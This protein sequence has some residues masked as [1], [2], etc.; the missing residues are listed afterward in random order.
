MAYR[1]QGFLLRDSGDGSV[2]PIEVESALLA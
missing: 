1:V 2:R